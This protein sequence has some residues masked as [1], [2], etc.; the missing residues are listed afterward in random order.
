MLAISHTNAFH[1]NALAIT[2]N[3]I[4]LLRISPASLEKHDNESQHIVWGSVSFASNVD[5]SA[6]HYCVANETVTPLMTDED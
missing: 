5:T 1:I 6:P 4:S 2:V 3:D